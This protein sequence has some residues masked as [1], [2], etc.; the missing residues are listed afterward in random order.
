VA[1]A[2][3]GL[4]GRP[5]GGAWLRFAA[6]AIASLAAFWAVY[7]AFVLTE[8]GQR[9]E[10][11][12]LLGAVLRSEADRQASLGRLSLI[13]LVSFGLAVVLVFLVATMRRRAGLGIVAAGVMVISIVVAEILKEVLPRPALVAGPTWILR[14]DFPSG[15][16]TIAAG[17]GVAM[18]LVSP[19]RLRWVVLP[20][21]VLIAGFIGQA[22][23]VAGWHR[24][25]GSIGGV[26]LV[27]AVALSG[28]VVLGRAGLVAPSAHGR[29][30]TRLRG[31]L[32]GP[33]RAG[34]DRAGDLRRVPSP[35]RPG[36]CQ[37]RLPPHRLRCRRLGRHGPRPRGLRG[38]DRAVRARGQPGRRRSAT[39]VAPASDRVTRLT[40]LNQAWFAGA[41][42]TFASRTVTASTS[43]TRDAASVKFEVGRALSPAS[44]TQ[45]PV[46]HAQHGRRRA[47]QAP[48]SPPVCGAQPPQ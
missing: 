20:A 38:D 4:A 48:G 36:G 12:G 13:S 14:N 37:R 11:L 28:L 15:T 40:R 44:G 34:R 41:R 25:S 16:S 39:G 26:L 42:E 7:A 19:D 1:S 33:D 45:T 3:V 5:A 47:R 32:V 10:N 18:L 43:P 22:T 6:A 9:S 8:P 23:Q 17:I 27:V 35:P 24:L 46:V 21:A 29:V 30:S 31:L 2:G